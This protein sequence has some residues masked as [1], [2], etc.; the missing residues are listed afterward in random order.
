MLR[1]V[2]ISAGADTLR[3]EPDRV[4]RQALESYAERMMCALRCNATA[5]AAT[6]VPFQAISPQT[7]TCLTLAQKN[8][9]PG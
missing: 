2:L 8:K 5:R 7:F 3:H 9:I 4:I 1:T 6:F